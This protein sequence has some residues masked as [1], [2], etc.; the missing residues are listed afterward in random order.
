MP[1]K[2]DPPI[3]KAEPMS[4]SNAA[5]AA[6][7]ENKGP[8]EPVPQHKSPVLPKST[9]VCPP[10]TVDSTSS[11]YFCI[12]GSDEFAKE[13]PN[14][15]EVMPDG[16]LFA[17]KADGTRVSAKA[18]PVEVFAAWEAAGLITT[19]KAKGGIA[20]RV[21]LAAPAAEDQ[22]AGPKVEPNAETSDAPESPPLVSTAEPSM[23]P[24]VAPQGISLVDLEP[25]TFV[26]LLVRHGIPN[27][28]LVALMKGAE[29]SSQEVKMTHRSPPN[30][31]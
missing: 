4:S 19:P 22:S 27:W 8:E 24:P 10:P 29:H 13:Y 1:W 5:P 31:S 15:L 2:V 9:P 20:G 14:G 25:I 16:S 3:P 17:V 26:K 6:G 21:P 11:L 23:V 12:D 7:S 28:E 30:Q 18:P